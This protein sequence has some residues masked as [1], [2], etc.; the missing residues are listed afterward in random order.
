MLGITLGV[1]ALITVLSVMNGFDA[2]L[3]EKIL[4]AN[5]HLVILSYRGKMEDPNKVIKLAEHDSRVIAAAPF[6]IT[7]GLLRCRMGTTGVVVRGV[8]ATKE[9]KVTLF[10]SS[11]VQGTWNSLLK[12]GYIILGKELAKNMGLFLGDP[13]T[14]V[15]TETRITPMG[16]LPRFGNFRVGAIFETGMYDLDAN[17][18][19]SSLKDTRMLLGWSQGVTGVEIKVKDVYQATEVGKSLVDKLGYPYWYRDWMSMNRNLFSA[20]KL[21][22]ITMFLILTLIVVVAAFNIVSTLSMMVVEKKREIGILKAMGCTPGMITKIFLIHG[23]IM[24]GVGTVSGILL[25]L[26]LSLLLKRYHFIQLPSDIYYVTTL[27]VKTNPRDVV[28][29]A[30]SAMIIALVSTVY[31]ARQAG[32][33]DPV[34]ALR[35]E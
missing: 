34:E 5:A 13:L 19:L 16:P 21:E 22:K 30:F 4:G 28:I 18:V 35:Y 20:L 6:M 12:G 9:G 17:L 8:K 29:I 2:H 33:L 11:L 7:Q 31:P 3:R 27:P 1:G 26:G 32:R 24:G 14:I 25:G 23:F 10:P 15:T